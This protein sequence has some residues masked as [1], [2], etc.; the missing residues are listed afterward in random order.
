[1]S[2]ESPVRAWK[3]TVYIMWSAAVGATLAIWSPGVVG[4]PVLALEGSGCAGCD[5]QLEQI[6]TIGDLLDP[7]SVVVLT[8]VVRNANG[9]Y[10]VTST[11]DGA[12]ILIYDADGTYEGHMGRR[13][14][15]PGEFGYIGRLLPL[16]GD[17][18]AALDIRDLSI[19]ILDQHGNQARSVPLPFRPDDLISVAHDEWMVA[20]TWH[21][22][23]RVGYVLHQVNSVGDV[24]ASLSRGDPV[25]PS[26]PSMG[27]R[28][29][30]GGE[31]GVW[32]IRPDRYELEFWRAGELEF[33]LDR[34]VAWFPDRDNEGARTSWRDSPAPW[35][36]DLE[37]DDAGLVWVMGIVPKA[38]WEPH[39]DRGLTLR[40]EELYDTFV[41]VIDPK[42][43]SVLAGARVSG[44][45]GTI[46][47]E[48]LIVTE[49]EDSNGVLL[50]DIWRPT[51]T[52]PQ[53]RHP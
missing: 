21:T 13:G 24:N 19:K 3:R 39:P 18:L 33:V 51:L 14:R 32:S 46:T 8:S 41:E 23:A 16:S 11:G 28:H 2:L 29:I 47:G 5:L 30:A 31:N 44:N 37:V 36:V 52:I 42:L 27:Q 4:Q 50:L 43:P 53:R 17:S 25:L 12:Q 20:G 7:Y 35:V 9:Q 34:R 45:A 48:G 10:L 26:R 38:G 22:P 1:M 49:R 15:G 6:V 40:R